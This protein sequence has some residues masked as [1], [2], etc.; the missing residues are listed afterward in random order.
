MFQRLEVARILSIVLT[1][2]VLSPSFAVNPDHLGKK[3]PC[4]VG[5]HKLCYILRERPAKS[6]SDIRL[7]RS[8][9]DSEVK[10][11][12][13]GTIVQIDG[14]KDWTHGNVVD[15]AFAAHSKFR[16]QW[17]IDTSDKSPHR[18]VDLHQKKHKPGVTTTFVRPQRVMP[19][20]LPSKPC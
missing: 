2:T 19:A 4:R 9:F 17:D 16:K 5:I 15:L 18:I 13:Y 14:L 7:N 11:V 3:F 20:T 12:A 1:F 10:K 8:L 6:L